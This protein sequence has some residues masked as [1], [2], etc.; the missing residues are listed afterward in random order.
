LQQAPRQQQQWLLV[1]LLQVGLLH[2]HRLQLCNIGL[3]WY[4]NA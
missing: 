3:L 1:L 2:I 4:L